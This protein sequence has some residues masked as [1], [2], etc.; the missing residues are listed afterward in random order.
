M[1]GSAH[2]TVHFTKRSK[3]FAEGCAHRRAGFETKIVSLLSDSEVTCL[4]LRKLPKKLAG[5]FGIPVLL[6]DLTG[7]CLKLRRYPC[8]NF[9]GVGSSLSIRSFTVTIQVQTAVW[10]ADFSTGC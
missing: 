9:F 10:D 4:K 8:R 7:T 1:R 5:S 6:S 2:Q 3:S